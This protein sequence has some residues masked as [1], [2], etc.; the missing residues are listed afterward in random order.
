MEKQY[1]SGL[2]A[3][4]GYEWIDTYWLD[5]EPSLKDDVGEEQVLAFIRVR[6]VWWLNDISEEFPYLDYVNEDARQKIGY[7]I[8]YEE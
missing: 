1:I 5:G 6:G 8:E 3:D 7:L 2:K 4:D